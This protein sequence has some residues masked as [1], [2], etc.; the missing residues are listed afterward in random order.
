MHV[1]HERWRKEIRIKW[2]RDCYR[3]E[4]GDPSRQPSEIHYLTDPLRSGSQQENNTQTDTI[5][6]F[7]ERGPQLRRH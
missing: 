3:V 7:N 6:Q 5:K 1:V 4:V 2:L